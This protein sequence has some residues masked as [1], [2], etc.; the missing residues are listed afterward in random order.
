MPYTPE[1]FSI[2]FITDYSQN[3]PGIIDAPLQASHLQEIYNMHF[4][5]SR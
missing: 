1:L 5:S 3:Y 4:A 2:L